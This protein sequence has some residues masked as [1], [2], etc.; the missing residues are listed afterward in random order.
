MKIV[1]DT[2]V[3]ISGLLWGGP[4]N[5]ILKWARDGLVVLIACESTINELKR[6]VQ[7]KRFAQRLSVL[8]ITPPDV[9]VYAMNIVTFAPEPLNIHQVI[10]VDPFDNI[11]LALASENEVH[12]IVSGDHHLL[13]LEEYNSI[14]ILKPSVAV[15]VIESL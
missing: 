12:L 3:L 1:A 10:S 5:R 13:D 8:K 7:Y 11:F 15:Q 2:N 14:Q 9:I 6:I 4:P